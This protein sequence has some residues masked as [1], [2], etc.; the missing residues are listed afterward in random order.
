[1]SIEQYEGRDISKN[2]E[3]T[4]FYEKFSLWLEYSKPVIPNWIKVEALTNGYFFDVLEA[5]DRATYQIQ[6]RVLYNF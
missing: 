4:E 3:V 6:C 1:R 2:I 5:Q